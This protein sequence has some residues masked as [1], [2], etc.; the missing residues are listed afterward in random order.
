TR[1]SCKLPSRANPKTRTHQ[2]KQDRN[3]FVSGIG[4]RIVSSPYKVVG[5]SGWLGALVYRWIPVVTH[6][7]G[8]AP[9]RGP[10]RHVDTRSSVDQPRRT[11]PVRSAATATAASLAAPASSAVKVRSLARK[12][13]AKAT[14]L[15]PLPTCSPV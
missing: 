15:C 2:E 1:T 13:S 7:G 14:D 6:H 5:C 9:R 3:L 11:A 12:R 8:V 4:S 10:P